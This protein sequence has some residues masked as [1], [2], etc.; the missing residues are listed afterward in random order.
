MVKALA[1]TTSDRFTYAEA[2]DCPQHE[3]WKRAM[4]EECTS[5]HHNNTFTTVY[6]REV[7]QLQ[8]RPIGSKWVH[9]TKDNPDSTI[10][11][12]ACLV[13]KGYKQTDSGET[14]A[15]VGKLTTFQYLILM[16][17][18]H[19]WNI[20]HLDVVTAFLNPEID[21]DDIYM[22]LPEGPNAA[23]I[24]VRLKKAHYSLKQAP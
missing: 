14:Y 5:I 22:T 9:K 19:G 7:G 12:K 8:V 11:Y 3:H 10:R 6:P 24:A 4:E 15:P 18:K 16:V 20:D 23:T 17:G 1:S 2:M 13:I 21:D